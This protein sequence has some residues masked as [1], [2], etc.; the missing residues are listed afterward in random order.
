MFSSSLLACS[1]GLVCVVESCLCSGA[2]LLLLLCVRVV[3][4]CVS[5][6][7]SL[8]RGLGGMPSLAMYVLI[9]GL[10][11]LIQVLLCWWSLASDNQSSPKISTRILSCVVI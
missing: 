11:V 4:G 10:H 2:L 9:R 5:V 6:S 1:T 3:L 8:V 7:C